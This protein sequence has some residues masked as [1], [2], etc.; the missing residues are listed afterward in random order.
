MKDF[1]AFLHALLFLL[2]LFQILF[3]WKNI[4]LHSLNS[5]KFCLI[6]MSNSELKTKTDKIQN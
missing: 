5:F 2:F 3:C 4:F 1:C 6:K